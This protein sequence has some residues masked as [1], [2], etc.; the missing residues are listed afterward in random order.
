MSVFSETGSASPQPA[1]VPG[2]SS[3]EGDGDGE[4]RV[5]SGAFGASPGASAGNSGSEEVQRC[6]LE[7]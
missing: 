2:V 7:G 4:F 1:A 3:A 6:R 5:M